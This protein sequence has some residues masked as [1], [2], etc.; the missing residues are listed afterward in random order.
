MLRPVLSHHE[1]ADLIRRAIA[2]V[3]VALSKRFLSSYDL[4]MH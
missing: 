2:E 3:D 4:A 1:F